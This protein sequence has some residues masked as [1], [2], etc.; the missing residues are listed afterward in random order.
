MKSDNG[1]DAL[2]PGHS[3]SP[4]AVALTN[5]L[6]LAWF[7]GGTEHHAHWRSESGVVKPAHIVIADDSITADAAFRF[8]CEGTA[9]L[10]RGDFQNARQ[11]M[12]AMARRIDKHAAKKASDPGAL[13]MKG[14]FYH[15][16]QQQARRARLLGMLLL[17]FDAG[18]RLSLR[19]A[20]NVATACDQAFGSADAPYVMSLRDLLGAIGAYEWRK[21]GLMLEQLGTKIHP[22]YGVFAPIRNEYLDL[23]AEA[24]LPSTKLA[25]DIGTGTGVLAALLVRR[26]MA[27]VVATDTDARAIACATDNVDRLG[28]AKQVSVIQTDLFPPGRAPLIACNPPW[29]PAQPS[30]RLE[31]AVY[32]TDSRMLCGFLNGVGAHLEAGGEA[33]LV[34]SDIAEHLGLRSRDELLAWISHGGLRVL[35]RLDVAAKH[36][37]TRDADDL[38]HRARA[39]EITSLWRLGLATA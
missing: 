10:W 33:W 38:L 29:I 3:I 14:S 23:V 34:L 32:D 16:R 2:R 31:H 25:F 28:L 35:G 39:A 13:T 8:V 30:S 27:K 22:H 17:Q 12:R 1:A 15:Q 37:R 19:R 4:S 24:P 20:P 21:N 36:P 26:G 18:H 5:E 11:L 7:E 9:L 6:T